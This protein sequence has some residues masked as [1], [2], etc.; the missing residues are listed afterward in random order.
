MTPYALT[1]SAASGPT[2]RAHSKID[3]SVQLLLLGPGGGILG[4][5]E[6]SGRIS[7]CPGGLAECAERTT[8]MLHTGNLTISRIDDSY[9]FAAGQFEF[10]ADDGAGN[11]TLVSAGAFRLRYR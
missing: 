9:G 7:Q 6:N 11:Q 5:M 10:T 3:V 8:D 1:I 4:M 2:K